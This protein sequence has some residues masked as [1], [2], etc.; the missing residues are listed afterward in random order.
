M[1]KGNN[2]GKNVKVMRSFDDVIIVLTKLEYSQ[3]IALAPTFNL[4]Y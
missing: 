2:F 3:R 4:I 1:K